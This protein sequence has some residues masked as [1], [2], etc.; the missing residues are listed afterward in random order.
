MPH[1]ELLLGRRELGIDVEE[2]VGLDRVRGD[3]VA[4]VLKNAAEPVL[5]G[6]LAHAVDAAYPREVVL[7]QGQDDRHVVLS[8]EPILA[9]ELRSARKRIVHGLEDAEQ[10]ERD[11]DRRE[12]ERGPQL[13]APQVRPEQWQVFHESTAFR[14]VSCHVCSCRA[15][16]DMQ[17]GA[18]HGTMAPLGGPA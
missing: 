16:D 9:R 10:Q 8:N 12:R 17:E 1:L 3:L 5:G 18:A 14:L 7:R 4:V 15:F 11:D 13:L 6:R 2:R